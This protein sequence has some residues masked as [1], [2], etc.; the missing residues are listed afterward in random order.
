MK[1]AEKLEEIYAALRKEPLELDELE[2]FRETSAAR[3]VK[4]RQRLANKL[5][6]TPGDDRHILLYG[7]KGCGKSTE[8][9]KLQSELQNEF[10]VVNFS[11]LEE[12]DP[13]HLQYIEI[14]IVTMERLFAAAKE[15][16][17]PISKEYLKTVQD[18]EQSK[19]IEEIK[20][21]YNLGVEVETGGGLDLSYFLNFFAKFKASA[22]SSLSLKET[23]KRVVEPRLSDLIG[24]CNRLIIE[25]RN[26]LHNKSLK[27]LL[28]IIEDI[29]KAPLDRA[30]D[31]FINYVGQLT[32][33]KSNIIFTFPLALRY[34][35]DFKTIEAS[36]SEH[37]ELPM[38][39]VRTRQGQMNDEG[40]KVMRDILFARVSETLFEDLAL[41]D[42]M[43]LLSGGCLRDFFNLAREAAENALVEN[44]TN[45]SREDFKWAK[46]QL[47]REYNASIADYTP[48]WREEKISV[49]DFYDELVR[50]A[51]NPRKNMPDETA[52]ALVL[53]QNLMIL[54]YNGEGWCDV[55]PVVREILIERALI[56]PTTPET[57]GIPEA[58]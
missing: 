36:F 56:S 19:E 57:Y 27:D 43:A 39:E 49:K 52:V 37:I 1:K 35:P 47:K 29:D 41:A 40:L 55:H 31:L 46:N 18:W 50:V 21:K 17:I 48:A 53:R 20:E 33:L 58:K 45:I 13:V 26:H 44:R 28:I 25:I 6:H 11:V 8:L 38:I 9:R 3:G 14:F 22:K 51:T 15:H 42:E 10:L 16:D 2:F 7:Y 12:L 5:R 34:T 30:R 32:Q 4:V 23:L 24:H 54:G